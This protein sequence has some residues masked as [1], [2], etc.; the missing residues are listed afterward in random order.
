MSFY[1]LNHLPLGRE[2]VISRLLPNS[3]PFRRKLL[4]MGIIPGCKVSVV[5]IAP[6]GDP[7]EIK[8]RGFLLCLRRNEASSI[9]VLE[10]KT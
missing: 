6:L 1:T 3:S 8:M 2:A 10:I 7:I 5:R 9:E 4:A